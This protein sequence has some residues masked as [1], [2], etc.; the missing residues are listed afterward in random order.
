MGQYANF[1][2]SCTRPI[3][4]EWASP[5]KMYLEL[6]EGE[7]MVA[8]ELQKGAI[9]YIH[10]Q[11]NIKEST[12]KEVYKKAENIWNQLRDKQLADCLDRARDDEKFELA[13][14]SVVYLTT[15]SG[16]I[17]D[18]VDL[19]KEERVA[20]LEDLNQKFNLELTTTT[21]TRKFFEEGNGGLNKWILYSKDSSIDTDPHTP[22]IVLE[23]NHQKSK[24][25]VYTGI[26]VFSRYT[27]IPSLSCEMECDSYYEFLTRFDTNEFLKYAQ[28]QAEELYAMYQNFVEHPVEV[29]AREMTTILKKVGYKIELD[30]DSDKIKPIENLSDETN[31]S[32]IQEY[33]NT[34][35][36]KTNESASDILRLSDFRKTFRYNKTTLLELLGILTKEYL[37]YNKSNITVQVLGDIVYKLT[38]SSLA[39]KSQVQ[40]IESEKEEN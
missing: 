6:E 25:R 14:S 12:S 31:N 13:K 35:R 10:K 7:K 1:L 40:Q 37:S 36:F 33:Y 2:T 15:E 5:T 32:I 26:L 8:F 3:S 20:S 38:N 28:E 34:F 39:D 19:Q 18:I 4:V 23:L 27:L 29:S 21:N 16:D 24:Y 9:Q 22:V 30:Y 11:I 17:V